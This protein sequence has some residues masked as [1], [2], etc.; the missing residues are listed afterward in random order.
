[1]DK[2]FI[3]IGFA[4]FAILIS[5]LINKKYQLEFISFACLVFVGLLDWISLIV[6]V[7]SSM[8]TYF[9]L[10]R[11]N[12]SWARLH[13]AVIAILVA[14]FIFFKL[15]ATLLNGIFSAVLPLGLSFYYFR[16]IHFV[17]EVYKGNYKQATLREFLNYMFYFPVILI[18]PII[19]FDDWK[20]EIK[21]RRWD[22]Q[23]F[24][25]GLER[26]LYGMVKIVIL[27]NYL[28]SYE[29][30]EYIENIKLSQPWMANYLDT[31]RYTGNSYMQFAGYSDIAIGLSMLFGIRVMENF[32]FPFLAGNINDF[33]KRWHIS[34]SNWCKDYIFMPIASYSRM[35]WLAIISSMLVLGLW[36]EFSSRYILWALFHG[37][38]IVIWHFYDKYISLNPK[39][40]WGIIYNGI[41][42]FITFN[43]VVI[44]FIW[45]KETSFLASIKA[46]KMLIGL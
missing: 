46:F 36:H 27:G 35:A 17:L 12:I 14:V 32:H 21:R 29:L 41:C 13:L 7:A 37:L 2:L 45:V 31:I 1:M 11:V 20:K 25:G 26:I 30:A 43:F 44:S 33:W 23:M 24:S 40:F 9:T 16:L 5:R 6:L 8:I 38:G 22:P 4:L 42:I 19:R 10:F 28:F 39:G 3:F 18:G 34:L 15:K